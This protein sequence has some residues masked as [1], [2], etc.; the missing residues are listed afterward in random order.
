MTKAAPQ[1]TR[2]AAAA[3]RENEP[4]TVLVVVVVLLLVLARSISLGG[5]RSRGKDGKGAPLRPHHLPRQMQERRPAPLPRRPRPPRATRRPTLPPA[6]P[7]K[8]A[9]ALAGCC[10]VA[11]L[12]EAVKYSTY[13]ISVC[14]LKVK[15]ANQNTNWLSGQE[16]GQT[17]VSTLFITPTS[18]NWNY[19]SSAAKVVRIVRL[20]K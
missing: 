3:L 13:I 5:S 17:P 16:Q 12:V 1:A 18:W 7:A 9:S 6:P 14:R 19:R 2:A 8:A 11:R 15:L 10:V 4:Q 20:D